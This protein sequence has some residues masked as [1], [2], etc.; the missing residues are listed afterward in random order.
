[1]RSIWKGALTFGLVNVPLRCYSATKTTDVSLHRCTTRTAGDPLPADLPRSTAKWCPTRTSTRPTTTASRRVV[2]TKDDLASLPSERS[3]E[4]EVVEFVPSDQVDLPDSRQGVLTRAGFL[5][6]QGVR[7]A[8]QDAGADRTHAIVRFSLRQKTR[9]AAS[10]ARRRA[11][12]A[13]RCCGPRGARGG[14]PAL[15]ES[16]RISAKELEMSASL[17]DSFSKDFDPEEFTTNTSRAAYPHR[18]EARAGRRDRHRRDLRQE[19]R[20]RRRRGHRSDGGPSRERRAQSAPPVRA[21]RTPQGRREAKAADTKRRQEE[22]RE[23]VLARR[24]GTVFEGLRVEGERFGLG[25]VTA[26]SRLAAARSRKLWIAMKIACRRR[27][28][29]DHVDVLGDDVADEGV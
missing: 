8:A 18:R 25:G 26:P 9:L 17:V 13:D 15:D 7:P 6:A 10:G 23:G 27:G 21:A 24:L 12:A 28:A 3:R 1:M 2:L 22:E 14:V 29:A 19:G 11:R 16:V 20:R 4:I 5:V